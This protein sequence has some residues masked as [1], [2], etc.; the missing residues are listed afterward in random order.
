MSSL[1]VGDRVKVLNKA[2]DS[3]GWTYEMYGCIGKAYKII[4]IEH[5]EWMNGGMYFLEVPGTKRGG[6]TPEGMKQDSIKGWW[7]VRK[8]LEL[9]D[10]QLLLFEV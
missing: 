3:C 2:S 6:K 5:P 10:K 7:F 1:K 4:A 9:V 8:E